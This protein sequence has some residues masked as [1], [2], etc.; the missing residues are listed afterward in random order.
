MFYECWELTSAVFYHLFCHSCKS[1]YHLTKP[2]HNTCIKPIGESW[3]CS[4][5]FIQSYS[6]TK[7]K[8]YFKFRICEDLGISHLTGKRVKIHK[9]KLTAIQEHINCCNYPSSSDDFSILTRE[10][11]DFKLKIMGSLIMARDKPCLN[12]A[13][14]SLPLELFWYDISDYHLMFY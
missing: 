12:K 3:Y 11:N 6:K 14:S 13:N 10:S 4:Y 5:C 7:T 2:M 8:R 9:N 1:L